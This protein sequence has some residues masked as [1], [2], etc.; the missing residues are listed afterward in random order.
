LTAVLTA[1]EAEP[2]KLDLGD[3]AI[4]DLL[5]A[6]SPATVTL[7]R[8]DRRPMTSPVW[9][10]VAGG[11]L[12]F[13]IARDDAK[14]KVVER[15]PTITLLVFE[16]SPPFR[17]AQW[18]DRATVTPDRASEARRAIAS[19]YMGAE[20]G[21]AYADESRRPPGFVVSLPFAGGRA[22]SLADKL[23]RL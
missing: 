22:W 18:A 6:P 11:R 4:R 2:V 1:T 12:E 8:A 23:P 7:T 14:L 19:R 10:R 3:D 5:D 17:G 15:D 21:Q 9:F 16:A 13:V 20:R